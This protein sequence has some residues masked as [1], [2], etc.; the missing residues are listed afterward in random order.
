MPLRQM[1][2]DWGDGSVDDSGEM[3]YYKNHRGAGKCDGKTFG[4]MLGVSCVEEPFVYTHVYAF[5]ASNPKCNQTEPA[6]VSWTPPI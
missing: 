1:V 2:I 3:N 6:P 4:N 5:D